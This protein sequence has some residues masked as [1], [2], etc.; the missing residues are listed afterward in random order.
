LGDLGVNAM[1]I[2]KLISYDVGNKVGYWFT[3]G[4]I[5]GIVK[6]WWNLR[7]HRS[8]WFLDHLVM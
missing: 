1:I 4:Y 3:M 2:L 8:K 5:R 6:R 7:F